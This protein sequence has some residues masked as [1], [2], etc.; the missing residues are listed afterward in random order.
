MAYFDQSSVL[1]ELAMWNPVILSVCSVLPLNTLITVH[2]GR[3]IS[4]NKGFP[5]VHYKSFPILPVSYHHPLHIY[6][7]ILL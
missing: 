6:N 7:D 1:P 4:R 2:Q 5:I 3:N